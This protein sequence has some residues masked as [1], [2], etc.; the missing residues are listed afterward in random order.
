M[1]KPINLFISWIFV[2]NYTFDISCKRSIF[3]FNNEK[4]FPRTST[5]ARR[6]KRV[7]SWQTRLSYT[8]LSTIHRK[9]VVRYKALVR[10][11]ES[12][13][14][15]YLSLIFESRSFFWSI[16]FGIV[17][18]ALRYIMVKLQ[19]AHIL[20]NYAIFMTISAYGWVWDQFF[21]PVWDGSNVYQ[22][23]HPM[24]TLLLV[25]KRFSVFI[26]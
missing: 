14:C 12:S 23:M 15:F 2:S 21:S 22:S 1:A 20:T 9:S 24:I 3:T 17:L 7:R 25:L 18:A 4:E 16:R 5:C 6:G 10:Q 8:K 11:R 19:Y 26:A 13:T